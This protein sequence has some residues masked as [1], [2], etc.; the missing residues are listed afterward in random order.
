MAALS[1]EQSHDQNIK[2]LIV[3]NPWAAITF[4][5]PKCVNFF[6]H[7]PEIEPIREETLKTLFSD[8]FL[9]MDVPLLAKYENLAFTFLVEHQHDP[10]KFSI[11]VLSRYVSHLQEQYK[12]AVIP[13]VYFPN[14]S[15]KNPLPPRST[16]SAFMGKRYFHFTY[17]AVFLKDMPAKKY[18]NS[19]N[20]IA[21]LMLPFMR[22]SR[23]DWM[24][25]LDSGVKA[26]LEMVDPTEGLRRN[27]YLD[28]LLFY[29]NLEEK[30]WETYRAYKHAQQK[31]KEV[32]MLITTVLKNQGKIEQG[33]EMLLS[34]LP[35]KLGPMPPEV[36]TS[37]LKLNDVE[38]ISSLLNRLLEVRDWQEVKQLIN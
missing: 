21:R 37:I 9:R 5:M 26:V 32:D 1:P 10:S 14:A 2:T 6:Q 15:S 7:E 18:L 23:Q 3:E 24:E 16:T 22:F 36:E 27:K 11:H 31:D 12:R 30:E 28:F 17:E 13:I 35:K 34:L 29:F 20:I 25:V 33:Q 8:S 38:R 19:S 4:A